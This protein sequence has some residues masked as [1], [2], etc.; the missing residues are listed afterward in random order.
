[1][2]PNSLIHL[3]SP[4]FSEGTVGWDDED[5]NNRNSKNGS[6]PDGTYGKDTYID[7]CCRSDGSTYTA[8]DLPTRKPF[9]L[10]RYSATRCQQVKN[11]RVTE[12]WFYWDD[13]DD[14]KKKSW[15][16]GKS[17]GN[18]NRKE[19]AHPKDTGDPYNHKLHYCYYY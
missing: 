11:M 10:F 4:G 18:K 2:M 12:E 13:E 19:G 6:L 9:Y 14:G 5:S 1:M 8:I 7:Y 16:G 17:K 3:F 15:W